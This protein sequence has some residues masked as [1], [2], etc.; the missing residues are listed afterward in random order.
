M[1]NYAFKGWKYMNKVLCFILSTGSNN[2]T[3]WIFMNIWTKINEEKTP[4]DL[5]NLKYHTELVSDFSPGG[6]SVAPE[7]DTMEFR[8]GN[9]TFLPY[10][11]KNKIS[12]FPEGGHLIPLSGGMSPP[13]PLNSTLELVFFF[14]PKLRKSGPWVLEFRKSKID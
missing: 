10:W 4:L 12:N 2:I 1:V 14:K 5:A 3:W 11:K 9:Y 7:R 6:T 13:P 8:G